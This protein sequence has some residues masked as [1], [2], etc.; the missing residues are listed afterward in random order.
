MIVSE[1]FLKK[2]EENR[3]DNRSKLIERE[4]N[5]ILATGP[6]QTA[7]AAAA[8]AATIH[9]FIYPSVSI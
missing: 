1:V 8:V 4:D 5:Y 3:G 7:P 9:P 2:I 6:D